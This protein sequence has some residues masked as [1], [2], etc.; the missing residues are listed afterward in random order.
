M[1]LSPE[2]AL[3]VHRALSGIDQ[4]ALKRGRR[5]SRSVI[6]GLQLGALQHPDPGARRWC[7]FFLDHY[8]N[9]QSMPV[10]AQA[11]TDPD[12]MV[13]DSALHSIACEPC[14]EGDLCVAD[15][16]PH[17]IQLLANDPEAR[18]RIKA[19]ATLLAVGDRDGRARE[20]L[21]R[22]AEED[23]DALVRKCA[24]DA[25]AG[26]FVAPKK[27]YERSQRRHAAAHH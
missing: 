27:R 22:A 16:A 3:L 18:L 10:F 6:E 7:L 8:A 19:I 17:V 20:A 24:Q 2:Q 26:R 5:L 23:S 1:S 13:R 21:R 15:A 25:L 14:K 4:K 9:D 11:M 12:A